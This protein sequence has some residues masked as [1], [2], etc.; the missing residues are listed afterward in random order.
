M[1]IPIAADNDLPSVELLANRYGIKDLPVVLIDEKIKIEELTSVE[2]IE[3]Y[4]A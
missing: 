1:L 2:D 4:L 3:K